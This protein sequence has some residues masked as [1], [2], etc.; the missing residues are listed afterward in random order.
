MI[1][2]S[3]VY[4]HVC[5]DTRKQANISMMIT[6]W[7]SQICIAS[8]WFCRFLNYNMYNI[9]CMYFFFLLLVCLIYFIVNSE[10]G[11]GDLVV[12]GVVGSCNWNAV[13]RNLPHVLVS[14][15]FN[16]HTSQK[17]SRTWSKSIRNLYSPCPSWCTSRSIFTAKSWA[18]P[19]FWWTW[20]TSFGYLTC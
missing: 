12:F 17:I 7:K 4:I 13:S 20:I 11:V 1:W 16:P 5:D 3:F 18:M 14:I 8:F 19:L 9:Y 2:F 10:E 15:I 6:T